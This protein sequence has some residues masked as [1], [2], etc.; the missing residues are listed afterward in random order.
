MENT[1]GYV[2]VAVETRLGQIGTD[3]EVRMSTTNFNPTE[4]VG[5]YT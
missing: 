1:P 2:T 5:E 3:V 4:A